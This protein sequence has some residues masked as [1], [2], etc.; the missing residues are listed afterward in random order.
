MVSNNSQAHGFDLYTEI[1]LINLISN[2][3][4]YKNPLIEIDEYYKFTWY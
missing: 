4:N 1:K 3:C 2:I